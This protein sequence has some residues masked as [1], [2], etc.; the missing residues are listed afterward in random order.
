MKAGFVF[1]QG[2]DIHIII[3]ATVNSGEFNNG[4]NQLFFTFQSAET[5]SCTGGRCGCSTDIPP[6][7]GI[8]LFKQ[9]LNG[10][11]WKGEGDLCFLGDG[12][13]APLLE[14]CEVGQ[15]IIDKPPIILQQNHGVAIAPFNLTVSPIL[16]RLARVPN[17]DRRLSY[18]GD[19]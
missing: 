6:P 5:W 2:V 12:S 10:T 18:C 1:I 8:P 3:N 13:Y 11:N 15:C 4:T 16:F 19:G 14:V 9:S 7:L 17:R